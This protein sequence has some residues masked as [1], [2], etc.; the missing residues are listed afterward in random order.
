MAA[1][2]GAP[3][4]LRMDRQDGSPPHAPPS[5]RKKLLKVAFV[6][7]GVAVTL[8]LGSTAFFQWKFDGGLPSLIPRFSPEKFGAALAGNIPW[9]LAFM[10]LSA[11]MQ[12]LRALQ[13]Q[14]TLQ[15]PVPFKERWHFVNI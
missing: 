13:W 14:R 8:A 3:T 1:G 9:L 10:A 6:V 15:K 4:F 12:P 2:K 5:G 7:F 11:V